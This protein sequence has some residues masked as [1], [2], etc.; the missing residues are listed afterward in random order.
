MERAGNENQRI[1]A[2]KWLDEIIWRE[3]YYYILYHFPYT[4]KRN[5]QPKFDSIKWENDLEDFQ[6]WKDG[7]TGYPF[8]DAGMRQ[9]KATGW[10]HNRL[11]MVTASFLVKNLLIDWKWGEL[12]FMQN[13]IDGDTASNAGGWQWVAG[14]GTDAAP[15]FRIFNPVTQSK[16]FDP[17]GEFIRTWLPELEHVPD[18]FIHTPW[19]MPASIQSEA[20]CII[21]RDY[22][23][24]IVDL[25]FSRERVLSRYRV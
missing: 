19:I 13:L 15:Y 5:F 4:V 12:W 23:K 3:F 2:E 21:G 24:P 18:K 10:M 16:K 17:S 8:I 20:G 22:P 7:Q 14:T 6:A 11:R 25:K 1:S 9:L